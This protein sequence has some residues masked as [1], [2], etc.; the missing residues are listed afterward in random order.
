RFQLARINC[1][2]LEIKILNEQ[3]YVIFLDKIE[4]GRIYFYKNLAKTEHCYYELEDFDSIDPYIPK[5]YKSSWR[6][7]LDRLFHG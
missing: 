6:A 3:Q 4:D 7:F 5:P 2:T 1:E